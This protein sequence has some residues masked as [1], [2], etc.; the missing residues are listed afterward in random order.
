MSG[1]LVHVG[2]GQYVIVVKGFG[3]VTKSEPIKKSEAVK[4]LTRLTFKGG[5]N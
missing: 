2:H 1:T 4:M 5:K 3:F